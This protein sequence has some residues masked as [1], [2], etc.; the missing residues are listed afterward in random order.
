MKVRDLQNRFLLL[1]PAS[2]PALANPARLSIVSVGLMVAAI[3]ASLSLTV[4]ADHSAKGQLSNSSQEAKRP[5]SA[6]AE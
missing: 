3:A 2:I 4:I 5:H 1:V 6:I